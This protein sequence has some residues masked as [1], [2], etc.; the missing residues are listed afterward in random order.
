MITSIMHCAFCHGHVHEFCAIL[1]TRLILKETASSTRSTSLH[2]LLRELAE[3]VREIVH[4]APHCV[5][6]DIDECAVN[7]GGCSPEANCT[8]TPGSF[9][10]TCHEGYSGDGFNCSGNKSTTA[11]APIFGVSS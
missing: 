8:N 9:N 10:C 6:T 3:V 2:Q 7:N 11:L 1:L 5:L 4:V